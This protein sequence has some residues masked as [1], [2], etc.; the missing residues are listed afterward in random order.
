VNKVETRVEAVWNLEASPLPEATKAR[1]RAALGARLA[2]D[3]TLRVVSQRHRSQ[4]RNR[5]AAVE[6][7]RA[8]VAAALRPRRVRRPTR[9]SE[10]SKRRRLEDKKRRSK[11]KQERRVE[12][13]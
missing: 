12:G 3:G 2:A 4:S 8:L 10:A 7:I 13:E 1:L 11:R 9:P 6:R 5:E